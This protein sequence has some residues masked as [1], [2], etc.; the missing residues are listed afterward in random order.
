[1]ILAVKMVGIL[2]Y[3]LAIQTAY[4][5]TNLPPELEAAI[6]AAVTQHPDVA[7]AGSDVLAAKAIVSAG[8][9]R[10]YPKVEV[11]SQ[12]GSRQVS[13]AGNRT[14]NFGLKQPLW[15]AGRVDAD[16]ASAK[17]SETVSLFA[18]SATLENVGMRASIA[19]F[20]VLRAREQRSVSKLS[21]DDHYGLYTSVSNRRVAGLGA[22]SDVALASSRLQQARATEFFWQGEIDRSESAYFSV[23]NQSPPS[24]MAEIRISEVDGGLLA[25]VEMAKARAPILK[26]LRNEV[27]VAEANVQS[28]KAQMFPTL[29]A[30]ADHVS[31]LG[32]S[33]NSFYEDDTRF[34]VNFEWQN[35]VAF[36][37]RFQIEAAEQKVIAAR[38]AVES[39]ERQLVE[40]LTGYWQDFTT[41]SQRSEELKKFEASAAET[42]VM[43]RRQF[44]IGRRSWPEVVNSLQ[45]LYS[46]KNQQ[47]EAKYQSMAARMKI[48]FMIGEMDMY[49]SAAK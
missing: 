12:A 43:F 33:T 40:T 44:T 16:F 8:E 30:R 27:L 13:G 47:V 17:A 38:F 11:S 22:K 6:R 7:M 32:G 5:A 21:A 9:Y 29:Y 20:N 42:V 24:D 3:G 36:T 15:D 48:A 45:D 26:K 25:A 19:Y 14:L 28:K 23:V 46:A 1:M 4:G 2:S 35:D 18:E 39:A 31:Y 34:T 49:L 37:Q 41:S 10:W